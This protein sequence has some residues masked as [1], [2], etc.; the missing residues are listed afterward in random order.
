NAAC[1]VLV[2]ACPCALGLAVPAALM[3]GTGRG[4]KR[5]ILIRDIDALQKAERID[6]VVLDKTG[7]I[8]RGRPTVVWFDSNDALRAAAAAEQYSSH[9]LA[10]AIVRAAREAGL[11][12]PQAAS[13]QNDPGYGV[14]AEIEG[15][16]ILVG[17][18]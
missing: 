17:S 5:G 15:R 3:V 2:I 16:T 11:D 1:S 14:V 8:T 18:D 4:A 13:F 12:V 6:T 7:T 9:P 10:Q